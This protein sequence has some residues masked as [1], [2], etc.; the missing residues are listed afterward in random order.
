MKSRIFIPFHVFDFL[1]WQHENSN[2]KVCFSRKSIRQEV[3]FDMEQEYCLLIQIRNKLKMLHNKYG[4]LNFRICYSCFY[5]KEKGKNKTKTFEVNGGP[6][7]LGGSILSRTSPWDKV[8]AHV[9]K[10]N[11]PKLTSKRY[12]YVYIFFF[13][14]H[15][16]YKTEKKRMIS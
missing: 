16:E 12:I 1:R 14:D 3:K 5:K 10:N 4:L 7:L 11:I 8:N 13:K 9:N 15:P 6:T 2:I